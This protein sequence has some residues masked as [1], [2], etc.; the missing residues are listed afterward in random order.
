MKVISKI[1]DK[2]INASNILIEMSIR[3]YLELIEAV[4]HKNE[5]QRKRVRSSKTV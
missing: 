4:I 5:F 1:E 2:R 3:E